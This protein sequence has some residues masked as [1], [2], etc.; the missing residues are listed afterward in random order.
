MWDSNTIT[1]GTPFMHRVSV[2]LQYYIHQRLNSDPGWM[3]ITVR[4][5][6]LQSQCMNGTQLWCC[7]K[8]SNER[9]L[10]QLRCCNVQPDASCCSACPVVA[11]DELAGSWTAFDAVAHRAA[12]AV[13]KMDINR[14]N[15]ASRPTPAARR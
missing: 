15:Q 4:G 3:N 14:Q 13:R 8:L 1:P 5:C 7:N 6:K 11:S 9:L 2:A 10:S 12:P